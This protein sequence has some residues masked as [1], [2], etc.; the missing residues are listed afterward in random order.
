MKNK[1]WFEYKYDLCENEIQCDGNTIAYSD[2]SIFKLPKEEFGP[3]LFDLGMRLSWM[4]ERANSTPELLTR[5]K[6]V[7]DEI[8][9]SN[10]SLNNAQ[11]DLFEAIAKAEKG[12]E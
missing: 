8:W 4:V 5:A 10:G 11:Q 7:L 9:N 6:A 3:A 12:R 2:S 1:F